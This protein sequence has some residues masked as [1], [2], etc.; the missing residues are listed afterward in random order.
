MNV[1]TRRI[2]GY[3]CTNSYKVESVNKLTLKIPEGVLRS[4]KAKTRQYSGQKKTDNG[5]QNT[6]QK[7]N[8]RA[9][10]TSLKT[11]VN[12]GAPEVLSVPAA[13]AEPVKVFL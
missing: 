4:D 8:D 10:G 2:F 5:L 3:I 13:L 1:G 12:C 11:G 6:A 7:V 9:T